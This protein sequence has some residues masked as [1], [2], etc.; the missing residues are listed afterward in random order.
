MKVTII[1]I[2]MMFNSILLYSQEVQGTVIDAEKNKYFNKGTE[3]IKA[4]IQKDIKSLN[5][6][7][8]SLALPELLSLLEANEIKQN[9]WVK[10]IKELKQRVSKSLLDTLQPYL[11]IQHYRVIPLQAEYL[12][13]TIELNPNLSEQYS[14]QINFLLNTLEFTNGYGKEELDSVIV[15]SDEPGCSNY[16]FFLQLFSCSLISL[17]I[18]DLS[19]DFKKVIG[20]SLQ[21]VSNEKI[22]Y[23]LQK[24]K[25]KDLMLR[26]DSSNNVK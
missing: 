19:E 12:Q 2:T 26:F 7:E 21:I 22:P 16:M 11:A 24:R 9:E 10:Y 15:I 6:Y 18:D 4:S 13:K 5:L 23:Y 1:I 17:D 14:T 25:W 20:L 3:E 8:Y